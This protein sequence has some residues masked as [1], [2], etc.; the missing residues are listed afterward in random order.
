M[1]SRTPHIQSVLERLENLE[2][3]NRRLRLQGLAFLVLLVGL[4]VTC[5]FHRSGVVEAERFVL[6]DSRGRTRIEIAAKSEFPAAQA[7]RYVPERENLVP[8]DRPTLTILGEDGKVQTVLGAG[9]LD[10]GDTNA[11]SRVTV[12]AYRLKV[13]DPKRDELRD[14][15][16][17]INVSDENGNV[18]CLG[19]CELKA[20]KGGQPQ[21][22]SAAS[23][24]LSDMDGKV[25][26]RTP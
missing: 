26:W 17:A 10:L 23:L 3:Q 1:I 13:Y 16:P 12:L 5:Q 24:V 15:G 11:S 6:R 19:G 22:T 18:A 25:I 2:R 14:I 4:L 8:E 7:V 20:P 21:L 9:E